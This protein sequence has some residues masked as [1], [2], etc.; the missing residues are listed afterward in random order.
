MVQKPEREISTWPPTQP[1]ISGWR[2]AMRHC[3]CRYSQVSGRPRFRRR[4]MPP[5]M[6]TPSATPSTTNVGASAIVRNIQD[7]GAPTSRPAA[8]DK[9][10]QIHSSSAV[11]PP[12]DNGVAVEPMRK[13][14]H[15]PV[16]TDVLLLGHTDLAYRMPVASVSSQMPITSSTAPMATVRPNWPHVLRPV[17]ISRRCRRRGSRTPINIDA[18]TSRGH[19]H[20]D[21]VAVVA[22]RLHDAVA[23]CRASGS[24]TAADLARTT[25]PAARRRQGHGGRWARQ[26]VRMR[27]AWSGLSG[28]ERRKR[29]GRGYHRDEADADAEELALVE[30]ALGP[31]T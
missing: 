27:F 25:A 8:P 6:N 19:K 18:T 11:R 22:D 17:W 10:Q 1:A 12:H 28:R 20:D 26:E 9:P 24:P 23:G 4:R 2:V 3:S 29:S 13:E 5:P 16:R 15:G 14:R 7:N 31:P 30:A 21:V